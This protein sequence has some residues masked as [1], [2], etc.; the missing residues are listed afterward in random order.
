[1]IE[2]GDKVRD[3]ITG[4]EG[5]VLAK[6]S[7]LY[8]SDRI[9]IQRQGLVGDKIEEAIWID[10]SPRIQ[11]LEKGVF[12]NIVVNP[13]IHDFNE[14]DEVEDTI[15]GIRGIITGFTAWY[16]GC[17]R[18]VVTTRNL[19]KDNNPV[20]LHVSTKQLKLRTKSDKVL[21]AKNTGGPM[22]DPKVY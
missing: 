6:T 21:E 2:I 10:V 20:E 4:Y 16:S 18:A 8:N 1:M 13:E 5:I 11:I 3:I 12:K 7:W 22:R 19:D 14:L 17:V 9:A 15:T